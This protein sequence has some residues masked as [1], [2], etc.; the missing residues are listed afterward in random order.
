MGNSSTRD[1]KIKWELEERDILLENTWYYGQINYNAK[2]QKA[3]F[4]IDSEFNCH[5]TGEWIDV[6]THKSHEFEN[7]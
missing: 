3:Q 4:K 2:I 1:T 5:C 7:P 6:L